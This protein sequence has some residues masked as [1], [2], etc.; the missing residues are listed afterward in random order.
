MRV[1]ASTMLLAAGLATGTGQ[2]VSAPIEVQPIIVCNDLGTSC[3]GGDY[4]P[5]GSIYNQLFR[6]DVLN[7]IYAQTAV[8]GHPGVSFDVLQPITYDGAQYLITDVD[9]HNS[10]GTLVTNVIDE[11]HQLIRLPDHG[12]SVNP[13]TLNV[14]LVNQLRTTVDGVPSGGTIHGYGLTSAN[15]AVIDTG[16]SID[17]LAHELGHDLGLLHVDRTADASPFNLMLSSGR[18]TLPLTQTDLSPFGTTYDLLN[19]A[20]IAQANA[21]LFTVKLASATV[22]ATENGRPCR[23]GVDIACGLDFDSNVAPTNE[24]L[25]GVQVRYLDG[26]W[27]KTTVV[28]TPLHGILGVP[29]NVLMDSGCD[30]YRFKTTPLAGTGVELDLTFNAGC[31]LPGRSTNLHFNS[32]GLNAHYEAPFSVGFTFEDGSTSIALFDATN[33]T[34]RTDTT[35]TVGA[36]DPSLLPPVPDEFVETGD[37]IVASVPEPASAAMLVAGLAAAIG[38]GAAVGARQRLNRGCTQT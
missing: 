2:A 6:S 22:T 12:Q 14:F 13:T 34:A 36:I 18:A 4:R 37:V 24:S 11:A 20:Q 35:V 32:D 23:P 5:A 8:N 38:L 15:G 1:L 21:P 30:N 31:L 10:G 29:G 9:N 26:T 28:D 27:L 16:A 7:K 25:T 33:G 17:T 19:A 3:A